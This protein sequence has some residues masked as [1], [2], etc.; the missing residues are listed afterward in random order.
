[1]PL[2]K[3]RHTSP[4]RSPSLTG[5]EEAAL[6]ALG[7]RLGRLHVRQ[8][9][10]I[11]RDFEAH[12]LRNGRH[13]FHVEN[14]HSIHGLIRGGLRFAGLHGRGRRNARAIE[15]RHHEVPLANLPAAFD[16]FTL[17]QLSDLHIDIAAGF[18]DALIERLIPLR[19]DQCVLTGDYRAR[20][21]GPF[22]AALAGMQRLRP[23][24]AGTP[25]AVLGNHDTIR[26][27]PAMEAMGY[28][29][30]LNERVTIERGGAAI[31]LL[32]IDDA[33]FYRLDNF[34][35]AIAEVPEQDVA[36]LLSRRSARAPRVGRGVPRTAA[37]ARPW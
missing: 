36:I 30:L 16:G 15:V 13:F 35:G 19:Y 20:T 24:I 23:H 34:A 18:V 9:L 4:L 33:H 17:L 29:L 25:Y 21:Y 2:N 28:R 3:P 10:G 11:E 22:D 26:M 7:Q 37:R 31:H 27:V 8:R 5:D 6:A 1:M 12:V 32:G 14:W